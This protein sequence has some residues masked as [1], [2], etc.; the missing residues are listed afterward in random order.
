MHIRDEKEHLRK[1]IRERLARIPDRARHA[2]S[3][4]LSRQLL[5]ALP[6]GIFTLTA[7]FP[8]KDEPDLRLLLQTLLER[9]CPVFLPRFE[10][11]K[12]VFR[13]ATD[14]VDLKPG[15][16]KIP[17]PPIDSP[18]LDPAHLDIALIPGRVFTR[19]GLRLG[20]GNGG[21]DI[22][23]RAQRAAN[24]ATKYWGAC[25]ECQLINELPQEPHDEKMDCVVTAR[26]PQC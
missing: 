4:T 14:L 22:W 11:K 18:L 17:E 3:R 6:Q 2:E 19:G 15:E 20:R 9:G 24:P 13:R 7:Y 23:I 12:M 10:D 25:Y 26:G 21:F 16:F 8:L 5:K 1:S